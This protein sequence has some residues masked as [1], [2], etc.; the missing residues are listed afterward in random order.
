MS[1]A[2]VLTAKG[3]RFSVGGLQILNGIAFNAG[4][5]EICG[6]VG[7]NGSGKSTFLNVLSGFVKPSEAAIFLG[8]EDITDAPAF[9]RARAGIGRSFQR[10]RVVERSTAREN[11]EMGLYS[12]RLGSRRFLRKAEAD[13]PALRALQRVAADEFADW[14]VR[15]LSFGTRRKI[16]VART[17]VSAPCVLLVDEPTAGVSRAHILA[18]EAVLREEAERGCAVVIV[19]HDLDFVSRISERVVVFDAGN[20][21]FEGTAKAAWADEQVVEAYLGS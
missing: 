15:Y 4:A 2:P 21:I 12:K 6:I 1:S 10:V 19:D 17:V 7:P 20:V 13:D 11:V 5:G 9:A 18:I 3:V 8:N 14:P 16:E